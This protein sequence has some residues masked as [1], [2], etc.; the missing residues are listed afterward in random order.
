M[1]EIEE[2]RNIITIL[3]NKTETDEPQ[4][5]KAVQQQVHKLESLRKHLDPAQ[6]KELMSEFRAN[7]L[8][9]TNESE[10][11]RYAYDKPRGYPGDFLTQE[12]IW[13]GRKNKDRKFI[14]SSGV[15][16]LLNAITLD[17]DNCKANEFRITYLRKLITTVGKRIASIGCGSCLEYW[18]IPDAKLR[19]LDVFL[20]DQDEGAFESARQH[21]HINGHAIKFHKDNIL[22]FILR[23]DKDA[24]IGQRDFIYSL[25]LLDYFNVKST[26]RIV[27]ELW[28]CVAPGGKLMFSNA[29]PDNP[30]KL[31]MEYVGDWFLNYK[32]KEEMLGTT[33]DLANVAEREYM[34]DPFGVYQYV[35]LTKT[36]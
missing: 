26:A 5:L 33:T 14:G 16:K 25:G 17:M 31:W 10:F 23:K 13:F 11:C 7:F 30:T 24:T 36:E 18:E 3:Q 32:T 34:L 35:T 2:F 8:P 27:A 29:H 1:K 4:C 6:E 9:F 12:M 15:G 28:S 19:T 22:K 20:L 21:M